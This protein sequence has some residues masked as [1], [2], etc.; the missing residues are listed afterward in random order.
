MLITESKLRKI[1]REIIEKDERLNEAAASSNKTY[2]DDANNKFQIRGGRLVLVTRGN[3]KTDNLP[4]TIPTS[5]LSAAVRALSSRYPDDPALISLVSAAPVQ[6][7]VTGGSASQ[8]YLDDKNNKF[9]IR[10][11]NLMLIARSSGKAD[12][13]P[14]MIPTNT[15]AATA[16]VLSSRYPDDTAL[17]TMAGKTSSSQ[18]AGGGGSQIFPSLKRN[19]P[20]FDPAA[21]GNKPVRIGDAGTLN[22]SEWVGNMLDITIGNAW[23][24]HNNPVLPTLKFDA[25]SNFAS[26]KSSVEKILK[27]MNK[28]EFLGP[29][30]AEA[31][32]DRAGAI[33]KA[34]I[35]SAG[36]IAAV[37]SLGDV[38][39]IFHQKSS[40]HGEALF[41][42]A[43]AGSLARR[44]PPTVPPGALID[45]GTQWN[46]SMLGQDKNF[47]VNKPFGLNTHV[48]FVGAI[49][50]GRA[51]VCHNITGNVYACYADKM[52]SADFPMWVKQGKASAPSVLDNVP[53]AAGGLNVI[54]GG[55][56]AAKRYMGF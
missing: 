22:C 20:L 1:V 8:V 44:F 33:S 41:D 17:S 10:N 4:I 5:K 53:S 16:G 45:D 38:V 55:L 12:G 7:A 43:T 14:I 28:D 11:G 2:S 30:N 54:S 32:N 23:H 18:P 40:H 24:A 29:N 47:V 13:L 52:T 6:P 26:Y 27:E 34:L 21:L 9:Q 46:Y 39:G 49:H 37:M 31:W 19:F 48:G 25:Y 51:I 56:K 15:L 50:N 35:P 3:G 36:A 42:G